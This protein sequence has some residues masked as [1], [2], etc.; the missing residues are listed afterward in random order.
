MA[1]TGDVVVT[2]KIQ[3]TDNQGGSVTW[4]FP[5]TVSNVRMNKIEKA[6]SAST[7]A[8]LW[9]GTETVTP[10][11]SFDYAIIKST[12]PIGVKLVADVDGN[13]RNMYF[14]I[15]D[16][17]FPLIVPGESVDYDNLDPF[18]ADNETANIQQ[19]AIEETQGTA[20]EV[21]VYLLSS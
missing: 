10:C 4:T 21:W 1:V 15:E 9:D 16:A 2:P 6:V 12:I 13:A 7:S 19:I 20:G 18:H 8:I 14:Y 5:F 3:V 17:D 11:T